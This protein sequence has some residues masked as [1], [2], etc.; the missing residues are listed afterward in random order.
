LF[1]NLSKNEL[2]KNL[3]VKSDIFKNEK[4]LQETV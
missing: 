3:K 1:D 2:L 4:K